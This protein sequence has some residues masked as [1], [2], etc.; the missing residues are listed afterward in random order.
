MKIKTVTRKGKTYDVIPIDWIS[1]IFFS[2]VLV[3]GLCLIHH[4]WANADWEMRFLYVP[5]FLIIGPGIVLRDFRYFLVSEEEILCCLFGIR[6]RRIPW[7]D[8]RQIGIGNR[9]NGFGPGGYGDFIILT[10][11]GCPRFRVGKDS[12]GGYISKHPILSVMMP[13]AEEFVAILEKHY[14][15]IDYDDT[16]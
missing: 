1:A 3:A 2:I 13:Y 5:I 10:L 15:P 6:F 14:G 9:R 7:N 4:Y 11:S 16:K 12:G 8:V